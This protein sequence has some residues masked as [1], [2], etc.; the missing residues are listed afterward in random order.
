M[1]AALRQSPTTMKR[2]PLSNYFA[3]TDEQLRSIADDVLGHARSLGASDCALEISEGSGLS[4]TVR[5]G[6]VETIEQNRDKSVSLTVYLGEGVSTRRG[7]ASSS[8]FQPRALADTVEAA[9]N[10]A[11]YTAQDDCASLPE[12]DLL[13]RE[14]RDFDLFHPWD[15]SAEEAVEIGRATEAAAF[16]VGPMI[17]NSDGATVSLQHGQFV[18]ANSRGF[19]GGYPYSRHSIGVAPIARRKAR[20]SDGMQRDYW[21]VS[22]RDPRDLAPPESIG[23]YAARR[24]LA[25]LDARKLQTCQ[26]PVL[27]EAPLAAG[28]LGSFAQ[29]ASGG[30]LYR[31]SSFLVD[32]LGKQ[33]F[34]E[35]IDVIDDPFVPRGMGSSAFDDEG[36]RT[37]RRN[38]ISGGVL[39]GYFLSCYSARK[40]G[41]QTTGNAGGS[42]NLTLKSRHTDP[43]DDFAAML[44]KMGTGLLVT[45][46]MGQGLNYVTGD[47]SRGAS[48]FWVERGEIAY[49]VEEITIAGNL[50]AMLRS[51]VAV[52]ADTLVYGN[53][54]SGSLLIDGLT[55]GGN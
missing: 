32:H 1:S 23:D 25:R 18:S 36:V 21:Y 17:R 30:P 39:E 6:E 40:L 43:D 31:K 55:I 7:S 34:S 48:G 50:A 8:D 46:L 3:Y 16:A 29:A 28:L 37:R 53:K 45:E 24:A 13:Q 22:M 10:I 41:L 33:V 4:A 11:R 19:M 47:Y 2:A 9:Y 49:P 26:A 15:L 5:M 35:H 38:V 12:T 42:H 20:G 51:I 44:R 14:V 54:Q 27:F 52:G